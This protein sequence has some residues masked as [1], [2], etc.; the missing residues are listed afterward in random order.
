MEVIITKLFFEQFEKC[1]VEFKKD[2][3]KIY[4]QLKIVDNPIEIKSIERYKSNKKYFKIIIQK[5]R[6]SIKIDNGK[7]IIA[8]FLYNEFFNNK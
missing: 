1:P 8:C 5:S 3:R 6:I 7:L 2:F 4:Q